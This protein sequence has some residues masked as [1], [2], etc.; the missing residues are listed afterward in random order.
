MLPTLFLRS[1]IYLLFSLSLSLC[2]SLSLSLSLSLLF[3]PF[4]LSDFFFPQEEE[5]VV[6]EEEDDIIETLSFFSSPALCIS[7]SI[8][9]FLPFFILFCLTTPFRNGKCSISL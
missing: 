9:I 2:L 6:D 7:G 8:L 1:L 3:S 5:V 4:T